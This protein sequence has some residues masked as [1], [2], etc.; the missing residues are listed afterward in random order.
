MSSIADVR[1]A[2]LF[3][4]QTK[5]TV[6]RCGSRRLSL[7]CGA[8]RVI[9]I[10]RLRIEVTLVTSELEQQRDRSGVRD[11]EDRIELEHVK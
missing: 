4:T 1:G 11:I 7:S 10:H 2:V 3:S 6:P 5:F 9:L 8:A